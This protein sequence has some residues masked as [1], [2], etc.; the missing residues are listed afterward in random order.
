M[1]ACLD[2]MSTP[3][4]ENGGSS[5]SNTQGNSD[6]EAYAARRASPLSRLLTV[7]QH[8]PRTNGARGHDDKS[9]IENPSSVEDKN[10]VQETYHHT[11]DITVHYSQTDSS[12]R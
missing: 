12:L 9:K 8:S 1:R 6:P 5:S 4:Q 10:R 7:P 3:V 11:K 2:E